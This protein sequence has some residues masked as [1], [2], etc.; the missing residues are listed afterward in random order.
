[1]DFRYR[2]SSVAVIFARGAYQKVAKILA[3]YDRIFIISTE[4]FAQQVQSI[5]QSLPDKQWELFTEVVQHVPISLVD[6]CAERLVQS[7]A[8]VLLALGGGSAI[9]LAKALALRTSLPI[10]AIPTTYAGSEM[11]NIWGISDEGKKTTGRDPIVQPQAVFY[12]PDLTQS[13]P[14]AI[15]ATSAMN[16]MAHLVEALYAFDRN[17][18]SSHLSVLG[19][20]KLLSGM[21][22]LAAE[23]KLSDTANESLLFG[24]YLAGKALGEVS[25]ALH[26]KAAHVLGGSFGLEHAKVH[27]VLQAYVLEYQWEGLSS[28][29]QQE[30]E[31][32]F[33]HPYPPR[34]LQSIAQ[35]MGAPTSLKDIGFDANDIDAAVEIM[36][37]K[38]YP[39]PVPLE[40]ERLRRMLQN[41]F[42][43]VLE[44]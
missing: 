17:P 3:A 27:T 13:M 19:I 38:P 1:M 10:I 26:H 37:Q 39:N 30:F 35:N 12:D 22:I 44:N 9:G 29:I 20:Q 32:A 4:R 7:K 33:D 40:R 41:A 31:T 23:G 36:L 2:S 34:A 6:R 18:I 25:M 16:A 43:G 15:A 8:E 11:T 24:A 14:P 5:I 42:E 28:L 21:Q